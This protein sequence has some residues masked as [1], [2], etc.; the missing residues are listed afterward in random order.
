MRRNIDRERA[1][2]YFT[3]VKKFVLS[4]RKNL[5][6]GKGNCPVQ[7]KKVALTINYGGQQEWKRGC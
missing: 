6:T 7:V 3:R 1:A 4:S 2:G 5:F